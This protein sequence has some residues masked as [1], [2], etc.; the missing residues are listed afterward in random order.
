M[1]KKSFIGSIGYWILMIFLAIHSY[2]AALRRAFYACVYC[3]WLRF[4]RNYV[5]WLK[6]SLYEFFLLNVDYSMP[7][8]TSLALMFFNRHFFIHYLLIQSVHS[9]HPHPPSA[10]EEGSVV[11]RSLTDVVW[12]SIKNEEILF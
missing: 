2:K 12:P 4:Q 3:M 7:Y 10:S 1:K 8:M 9:D 6:P 5:G 11:S